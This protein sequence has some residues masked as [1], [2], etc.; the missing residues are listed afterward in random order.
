MTGFTEVRR[1]VSELALPETVREQACAL[2]ESAQTED[3]L[4][5][6]SI[7]GFAAAAVYA[8]CRGH[9]PNEG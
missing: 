7:E 4:V 9:R 8:T 3:L 5:G 1:I 2:F 6:R